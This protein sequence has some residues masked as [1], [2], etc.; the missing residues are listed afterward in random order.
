MLWYR[1]LWGYL[2][3]NDNEQWPMDNETI[4]DED[5]TAYQHDKNGPCA[6]AIIEMGQSWS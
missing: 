6:S 5:I 3:T 4:G 1:Q 2:V